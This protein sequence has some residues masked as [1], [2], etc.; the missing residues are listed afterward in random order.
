MPTLPSCHLPVDSAAFE[1]RHRRKSGCTLKFVESGW[2]TVVSIDAALDSVTF[3]A[4]RTPA[5]DQDDYFAE[6]SHYRDGAMFVASYAGTTEW[7]CHGTGDEI[8]LVINGETTLIL[9][10]DDVEI[11]HK[12]GPHEF[13]VVPQ[14]VWHRFE[15][16][17]GVQIMS[18]TPQPTDHRV[19]H[20]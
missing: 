14:A 17:V 18:V 10:I 2:P 13:L 9:L 15:T 16:P 1:R 6:L 20:P 11:S 12:L 8:V 3:L 4:D 5:T 19:D 7:E